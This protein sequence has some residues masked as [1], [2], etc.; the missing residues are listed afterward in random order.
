MKFELSRFNSIQN[1][2]IYMDELFE[3]CGRFVGVRV[4][5]SPCL[6]KLALLRYL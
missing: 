1:I 3:V 4:S 6:N 2:S 5:V